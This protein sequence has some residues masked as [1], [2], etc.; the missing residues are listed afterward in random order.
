M[1]RGT[2]TWGFCIGFK[3]ILFVMVWIH[4]I[5]LSPTMSKI[6]GIFSLGREILYSNPVPWSA[7][8]YWSLVEPF[9]ATDLPL[10]VID[11]HFA[12]E[13]ERKCW[14]GSFWS[15]Q[16]LT[17]LRSTHTYYSFLK[18]TNFIT[19][20]RLWEILVEQKWSPILHL[21]CKDYFKMS[22]F[23]RHIYQ[24]KCILYLLDIFINNVTHN[25]WSVPSLNIV[26]STL[27]ALPWRLSN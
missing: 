24:W 5:S 11:L 23:V 8:R 26:S 15:V 22:R 1:D 13:T 9:T 14:E 20:N 10:V 6:V 3:L 7:R 27:I 17:L 4:L 25:C 19:C 18:G 21:I 16:L 12:S 2:S